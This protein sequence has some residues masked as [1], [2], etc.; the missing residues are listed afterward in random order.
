PYA[1]DIGAQ[2][3]SLRHLA[4]REEA[5]F[6]PGHGPITPRAE[7]AAALDANI[8]A[9][10]H[11]S[12]LVLAALAEPRNLIE[13]GAHV[14]QAYG[15]SFAGLPQYAIFLSAVSAHL[16]WLEAQGLVKAEVGA[17]WSRG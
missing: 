11:A 6:V 1:H 13:I 14:Q 15:L 3:A 9:V 4:A 5:F 12:A 2:L 17:I 7:L 16:S 8:A 10:E